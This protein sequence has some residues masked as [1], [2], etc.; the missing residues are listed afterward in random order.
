MSADFIILSEIIVRFSV[1]EAMFTFFLIGI[2][3]AN[4]TPAIVG[5]KPD[6]KNK[7]QITM[8]DTIKIPFEYLFLYDNSKRKAKSKPAY[9]NS[10]QSIL[11]L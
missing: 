9:S 3:K 7:N 2:V 11:A 10:I 8:A 5:C 4:K 6:F 1:N